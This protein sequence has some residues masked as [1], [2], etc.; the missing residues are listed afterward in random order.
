MK[1]TINMAEELGMEQSVIAWEAEMAYRASDDGVI[2]NYM[3][4]YFNEGFPR[5]PDHCVRSHSKRLEDAYWGAYF[6][7][8]RSTKGW[9]GFAAVEA[10]A[11]LEKRYTPI[12]DCTYTPEFGPQ[13]LEEPPF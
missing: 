13:P 9:W 6:D 4:L 2:E 5:H 1:D 8:E 11:L 7:F 3:D 10:A 12:I